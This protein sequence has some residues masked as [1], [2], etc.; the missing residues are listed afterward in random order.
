MGVDMRKLNIV[1]DAFKHCL[2]S[3]NPLPPTSFF[4]Q[5]EWS[6]DISSEEDVCFYVD[7]GI[8]NINSSKHNKNVCWLIEPIELIPNIYDFVVK[9]NNKFD[10]VFTHE[11]TLLS[12]E[13]NFKLLPYGGCWIPESKR[14]MPEY[15]DKLVSIIASDKR[16]LSG[17]KLR[18][19]TIRMFGSVLDVYGRGYSPVES[20]LTVHEDYFFSVVIENCKRDYWFTEKLIDSLI[21]GCMPIYWGCPS[22]GDFF[23]TNGMIIVD[24][25]DCIENALDTITPDYYLERFESIV[26]NQELAKNYILA[27]Q[28]IQKEYIDRRLI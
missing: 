21:T 22:I 27:E 13:Q 15:K 16:F 5:I 19:E 24:S 8:Q 6:W 4:N 9:N 26:K 28:F 14:V 2:Y 17:H 18:H 3:N 23:D 7:S 11:K 1:G 20:K 12:R 25:I 10:Y